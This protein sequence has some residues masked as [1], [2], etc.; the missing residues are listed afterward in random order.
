MALSIYRVLNIEKDESSRVLSFLVQSVFIGIFFGALDVAAHA[1]FLDV[2]PATFIPKGY[3]VSGIVGILFTSLYTRL[4]QRYEFGWFAGMNLLIIALISFLLWA[5]FWFI[6]N[7]V[8]VFLIFIFFGPLNI[9]AGLG[10]WGGVGRMFTL[11]QG[12]RIFGLVDSGQIIGIILSSYGATL[13]L[14]VG[15]KTRDLLL[16]S[17]ASIFVALLLQLYITRKF[18]FRIQSEDRPASN[19]RKVRMFKLMGDHYILFLSFFV[20]LSVVSTFFIHYTFV[21]V[22]KENYPDTTSLAKFL[23]AFTGTMMVATLLVKT[24]VY[25]RLIKTYGL[26]VILMLSPV[27]LALFTGISMLIGHLAGFTAA[28][29]GFI[30]FFL[31]ISL[32]KLFSKILRD[33]MEAPS[34]KVLYQA[35]QQDVRF[36]VQSGVDGTINEIAAFS[37]GLALAGLVS[38]SFITTIHFVYI[39]GVFL[40]IWIFIAFRLYSEYRQSLQNSLLSYQDHALDDNRPSLKGFLVSMIDQGGNQ[41]RKFGL[42]LASRI[43]PDV[44][45][46]KG[47]RIEVPSPSGEL[48]SLVYSKDPIHRISCAYGLRGNAHPEKIRLLKILLRDQEASV[49]EAA[50]ITAGDERLTELASMVIENL[51]H[52]KAYPWA[53]GAILKMGEPVLE[54][55]DIFFKKTGQETKVQARI[56]RLLSDIGGPAAIQLLVGKLA[57][58]NRD[59]VRETIHALRRLHY[60]FNEEQEKIIRKTL[61]DYLALMAWNTAALAGIEEDEKWEMLQSVMQEET[62]HSYEAVM[63]TLALLFDEKSVMLVKENLESGTREGIGY[64]LELLDLFL[65]DDLKRLILPLLEDHSLSEKVRLLQEEY[66]VEK[67]NPSTLLTSIMNRSSNEISNIARLMAIHSVLLMKH[68]LL[69]DGVIAHLFNDSPSLAETALTVIHATEPDRLPDL[70]ERLEL[71]GKFLPA[72]RYREII[73]EKYRPSV[74]SLLSILKNIPHLRK[75]SW[76]DLLLIAERMSPVICSESNNSTLGESLNSG[77]QLVLLIEGTIQATSSQNESISLVS[78]SLLNPAEGY[79]RM[80]V[81]TRSLLAILYDQELSELLFDFPHLSTLFSDVSKGIVEPKTQMI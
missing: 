58:F 78:G 38:L 9:L 19:T 50:I 33:S 5:G 59:I 22:S 28:S 80:Q 60:Q 27:L 18:G 17:A 6:P 35:L 8:I 11:R 79:S 48:E 12:K 32:T 51:A 54:Q 68:P 70:L 56:I 69:S 26:K 77:T 2:Y 16:I 13:I 10:F 45:Q 3:I 31:V 63:D 72:A 52:H 47:P 71:A 15:Y 53:Y 62:H 57:S 30:L 40:L 14:S 4:Q 37:S 34:F 1:L 66:P 43:A 20:G 41:A 21:T 39:L 44:Y 29:S 7:K 75:T 61:L 64:A 81:S 67:L 49:R 73:L 23:G 76:N 74:V 42:F 55:L 65:D 25:G 36:S 46:S 24:F